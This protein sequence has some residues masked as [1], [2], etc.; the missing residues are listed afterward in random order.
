[1]VTWRSGSERQAAEAEQIAGDVDLVRRR[2]LHHEIVGEIDV[3]I[4]RER[5]RKFK[6]RARLR[7]DESCGQT[8]A[9]PALRMLLAR[10]ALAARIGSAPPGASATTAA[11]GGIPGITAESTA[12]PQRPAVNATAAE[13]TTLEFSVRNCLRLTAHPPDLLFLQALPDGL[14]IDKARLTRRQD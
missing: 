8:N 13:M 14:A 9:M 3:R 7:P 1:M 5:L 10:R 11:G 4:G 2:R 6:A 12:P